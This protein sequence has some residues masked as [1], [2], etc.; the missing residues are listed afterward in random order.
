MTQYEREMGHLEARM[1]TVE[2]ELQAIRR[3]VR[4]IRDALVQAKG[5]WFVLTLVFAA[6]ASLGAFASRTLPQILNNG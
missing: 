5:G 2:G 4:E 3:D 6:A 1:E